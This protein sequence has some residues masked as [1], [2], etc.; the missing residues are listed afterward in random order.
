MTLVWDHFPR[1]GSDKLAMLSMADWAD[2]KGGNVYPSM[3]R[4]AQKI[5]L[6]EKQARRI[7]HKLIGE[8]WLAVVKNQYGGKPGDTRHYRVNIEKLKQAELN[9]TAPA[10]VRG[11]IEGRGDTQGHDGSRQCPE[12]APASGSQ[13]VSYP[14]NIRQYI[15]CPEFLEVKEHYPKRAGGNSWTDAFKAWKARI[16]EGHSMEAMFEGVVRYHAFCEATEKLNTEFVKQAK[17]F[18]GPGLHFQDQWDIPTGGNNGT[19][20]KPSISEQV[21]AA[22]SEGRE[23]IPGSATVID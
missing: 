9:L 20:R 21:H 13:S 18:F 16:K 22:N 14:S 10:N 17:T 8:G 6:S 1:G 7:I 15:S 5:C 4:I 2:D 12:T 19:G 23:P 3:A 11:D